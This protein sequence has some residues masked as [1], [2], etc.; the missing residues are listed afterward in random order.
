MLF[1]C[2]RGAL[3][4][5]AVESQHAGKVTQTWEE[6]L[7]SKAGLLG[8]WGVLTVLS[9][10][11]RVKLV[12]RGP[13]VRPGVCRGRCSCSTDLT[14]HALPCTRL[15]HRGS[16]EG[17]KLAREA[18]RAGEGSRLMGCMWVVSGRVQA[19]RESLAWALWGF[20][21]DRRVQASGLPESPP[22]TVPKVTLTCLSLRLPPGVG[23]LPCIPGLHCRARV[24]EATP[25]VTKSSAPLSGA[26][27]Q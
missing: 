14:S 12:L 10:L 6:E 20:P 15:P 2:Y 18:G 8:L 25:P 11:T 19:R 16:A 21:G 27:L 4:P 1:L 26:W 9:A 5:R 13:L 3:E 24:L 22:H 23:S 7:S 17:T